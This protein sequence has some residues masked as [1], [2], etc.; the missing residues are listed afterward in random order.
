MVG[1]PL[2]NRSLRAVN[3]R[4]LPHVVLHSFVLLLFRFPA[5]SRAPPSAHIAGIL[6]SRPLESTIGIGGKT[7]AD[8]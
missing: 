1:A 2:Y 6:L 4:R 3:L 8:L 7:V 5:L